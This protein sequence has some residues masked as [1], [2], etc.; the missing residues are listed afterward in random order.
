MYTPGDGCIYFNDVAMGMSKGPSL[1]IVKRNYKG[2]LWRKRAR[3]VYFVYVFYK[4]LTQ[5]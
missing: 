4:K 3:N 2:D 5:I 1:L